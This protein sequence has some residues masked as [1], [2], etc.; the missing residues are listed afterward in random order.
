MMIHVE[1]N[2]KTDSEGYDVIIGKGVLAHIGEYTDLDRRVVIVSDDGV[3]DEYVAAAARSCREPLIFRFPAGEKSKNYRTYLDLLGFM[4][5]KGVCRTDCV[6]AVGGGVS[7]DLAGFAAATYMRGIDFVLAPT[8]LLAQADSSIGGK[9]GIDF[10]GVK[11][12]VGAFVRPVCVAADTDT[13]A[14]LPQ[15][16]IAAGMAEIVKMAATCDRKLFGDIEKMRAPGN[17]PEEDIIARAIE[18]KRKIVTED[19]HESGLRR[20]LNFGHTVGHAVE[21]ASGGRLLHGECVA[22]GMIPFSRADARLRIADLLKRIGL[23]TT[24]P[25]GVKI[26]ADDIIRLARHDKKN[27]GELIR[28]VILNGIGEWK[29]SEIDEEKL[30]RITEES[31]ILSGCKGKSAEGKKK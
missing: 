1:T 29:F 14:T 30:R 24:V 27:S 11:N 20:V 26:S 22:I 2:K 10:G 13:L 17:V 23:P 18:I 15:R 9:T 6:L 28:T 12:S 21:A 7:G 8:T 3:P 31:G 19:E 5:E 25:E 4:L 16:Q